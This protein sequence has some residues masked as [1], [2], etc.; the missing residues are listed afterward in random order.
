MSGGFEGVL[1]GC[2]VSGVGCEAIALHTANDGSRVAGFL[3][4][5]PGASASKEKI[6]TAFFLYGV[7]S[8]IALLMN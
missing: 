7:V 2:G 1:V 3:T 4:L 5:Y 8:A 6:R